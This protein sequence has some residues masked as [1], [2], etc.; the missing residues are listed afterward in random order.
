MKKLLIPIIILNSIN[1]SASD[2]D[3]TSYL[4]SIINNTKEYR[5]YIHESL[6]TTSSS[7]DNYYF[8]EKEH[9]KK[10]Y[11]TTYGLIELSSYYNQHEGIK[12]DQKVRI[13]LELPKLKDR[14]KLLFESDDERVTKDFIEDHTQNNNDNFNLALA[15]NKLLNYDIDFS[16]KIGIKLKSNLN[17][18]VKV[19]AKKTWKDIKGIDYTVSQALKE[20]VDKNL[21][22][23]S[24]LR[25]DK[26][27]N[28]Y[29]SVHNYNEYYWHSD[30]EGDSEFY[31]SVYLNQKLS[32]KNQLSY[33]LD[34]NIDNINSDIKV[35]RYSAK[36]GFRH[37]I[38][39]WLYTDVVPENY[40][41]E[42]LD[43]KPKY[44]IRVNLGMYLNKDSY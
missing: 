44:A 10:E 24:Y 37:F 27:L 41:K 23:T 1:L 9:L 38:K 7:I 3:E 12:F 6:M 26:K 31:H 15:Y 36:V 22:A 34:T 33:I 30:N 21:E 20:S 14:L 42:D 16:T 43:F 4:D 17:P 13:K 28:D 29:Y 39:S 5:K 35:K 25:L 19:Q 32:K 8:D 2:T 11:N 18:F 40:Y